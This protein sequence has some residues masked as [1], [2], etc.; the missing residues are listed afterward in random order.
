CRFRS[1]SLQATRTTAPT[2]LHLN[3]CRDRR[4]ATNDRAR[5]LRAATAAP[6]LPPSRCPAA[7]LASRAKVAAAVPR[8]P[9]ARECGR[10]V[11]PRDDG[12]RS[13][14]GTLIRPV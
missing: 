6:V 3:R 2:E 7:A 13:L 4:C 8:I 12:G 14:Q 11:L 5:H 1:P 10:P 9:F